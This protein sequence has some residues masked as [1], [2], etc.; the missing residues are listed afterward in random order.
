M[1]E[2]STTLHFSIF[3]VL[4]VPSCWLDFL[5]TL[6]RQVGAGRADCWPRW[7]LA[8]SLMMGAL[9]LIAPPTT[10]TWCH[11]ASVEGPGKAFSVPLLHPYPGKVFPGRPSS[12]A[13]HSWKHWGAACRAGLS[14]GRT[15]RARTISVTM[16]RHV[17]CWAEPWAHRPPPRHTTSDYAARTTLLVHAAGCA[18]AVPAPLLGAG[19]SR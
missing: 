17:Q 18:R 6:A 11:V 12:F 7:R 4:L 10:A 14:S 1:A 16:R 19:T 8:S 9:I 5:P 3:R 2:A 15:G 13:P